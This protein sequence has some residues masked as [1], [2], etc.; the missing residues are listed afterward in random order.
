[1]ACNPR[2]WAKSN[3]LDSFKHA[4]PIETKKC[5]V[6]VTLDVYVSILLLIW[7]VNLNSYLKNP[8]VLSIKKEKL[9]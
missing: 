3:N 1:M 7:C 2:I 5:F 6:V 8:I 9:A 4:Q